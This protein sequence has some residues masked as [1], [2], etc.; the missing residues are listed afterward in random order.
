M[1]ERFVSTDLEEDSREC[2]PTSNGIRIRVGLF[3]FVLKHSRL[4][5][6]F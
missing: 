3:R 6:Q 5:T 1:A 4:I 2:F